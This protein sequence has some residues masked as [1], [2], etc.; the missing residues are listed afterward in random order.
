MLSEITQMEVETV[1][2]EYAPETLAGKL[3]VHL[4][5]VWWCV[6]ARRD[7]PNCTGCAGRMRPPAQR[8]VL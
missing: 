8:L 4:I 7:L 1:E 2:R 3:F 6:R 5:G